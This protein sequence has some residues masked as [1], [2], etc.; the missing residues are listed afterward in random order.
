MDRHA[1]RME[2]FQAAGLYLVTGE[3]LSNGRS[4]LEIVN[5]A[6]DGGVR[7]VQLRE[8]EKTTRE[9][10]ELAGKVRRLC[11]EYDA[12]F[13]IND[14]VDLALAANAD[15][16]HL[17]NDD[18]RPAVARRLFPDGII[19]VS[20]HSEAEATGLETSGA[21]YFNIGPIFPTTTKAW[22]DAFLGVDKI[23]SIA[24]CCSLP[25]TVM[26]GIKR[27][28]IEQVVAAGARTVAVVSAITKADDPASECRQML[29]IIR[30]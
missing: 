19:G 6:L 9:L 3:A 16:V 20:T 25:F 24:A 21:S 27:S 4:T 11:D 26:G 8:K 2:R 14:R 22:Y 17:G 29:A 7:L 30:G 1:R 5:R 13:I 12:L 18:L 23:S 15:G 28:N 10:F